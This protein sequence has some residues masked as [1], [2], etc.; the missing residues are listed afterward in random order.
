LACLQGTS[1]R[2]KISLYSTFLTILPVTRGLEN[3]GKPLPD[4]Y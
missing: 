1:L 4:L 3:E 2:A